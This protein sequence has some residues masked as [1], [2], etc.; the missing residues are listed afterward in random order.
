[1][2]RVRRMLK[3]AGRI[4]IILVTVGGGTAGFLEI[5]AHL[6]DSKTTS[7][8]A[9]V[10]LWICLALYSLMIAAGLVFIYRPRRDWMMRAALLLQIPWIDLQG[11]RYHLSS[12][13]D[14]RVTLDSPPIGNAWSAAIH[15]GLGSDVGIRIGGAPAHGW[16]VGVNLF[17]IF[18]LLV[19]L[20]YTWKDE[21][22][23]GEESSL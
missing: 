12:F 23:W 4:L 16:S 2:E 5:A 14:W 9:L 18:V 15:Y 20:L 17:A 7:A 22:V 10:L 3:T 1:M 6:I 21:T 19:W 8:A 13:A 11:F